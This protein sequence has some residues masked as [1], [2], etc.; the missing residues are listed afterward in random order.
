MG[1]GLFGNSHEPFASG[2]PLQ[3][4]CKRVVNIRVR[5]SLWELSPGAAASHAF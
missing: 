2:A 3:Q 1:F 4:M 5:Q